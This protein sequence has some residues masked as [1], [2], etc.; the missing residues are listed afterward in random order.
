MSESIP[1]QLAAVVECVRAGRIDDAERLCRESLAVDRDDINLLGM[2]GAILLKKGQYDEA[3]RHLLRTVEL[4]P[5]FAKPYEDLGTLHLA[6]NQP[7][8]A[9]GFF[10]Q[11]L[12]LD[13][14]LA[15]AQ[16]GLAVALHRTGRQAEAAAV[17]RQAGVS[18]PA[19]R[20][21][22]EADDLRRR[23]AYEEAEQRCQAVLQREPENLV[24]LRLL[25]MIAT[26]REQFIIA[27][28][29]LRRI[30]KIAPN[31]PGA[32]LD[33]GRFLS[34]RGRYPEGIAVLEDAARQA[35][36]RPEV[37][38]LLG[39]ML[40]VVGRSADALRCY[41]SC[42]S[43]QPDDP[44]ALLGAAHMLRIE[45]RREAAEAS[46]R[47]CTERYPE[48]GE[49]WWNLAS[50]RGYC[51]T[52]TEFEHMQ[53]ALADESLAPESEV[54]FRFALARAYE[55]REDFDAAWRQYV[56]GNSRKRALV[57]Y[58]P[59]ETELQHR[60]IRDVFS[61]ELFRAAAA[62]TPAD[63]TP[64]FIVGMPRS[65]STLI[66]QIL[67][68]HSQVEG[69]GE[70]PYII[71]LTNAVNATRSDGLRYPELIPGLSASE[72]T[73]L[74]RS[75]LHH[76]GSHAGKPTRFFTDK[77]PANFSHVGFIRLI[78]PQARIIDARRDPL[79]TCVANY[80]QLFAQG[81]NQ[82]YDLTELGEYYLQY[83]EMMNHWDA[84]IP[85]AVLRVQYEQ[86]VAD[87]ETEVRRILE[88]CGL[89][90][91]T[92]CI[93]FHKSERPV[94]TASAEQVREPIYRT[95]VDYWKHYEPYLDEL[96]EVLAPVL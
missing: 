65:G 66:E 82:T 25:A 81:K 23:E 84:V 53:A 13:S 87:L 37:Q 86:V 17:Q 71:M 88:Y 11:A 96:R 61:S 83:V 73:G 80:R 49:A 35:G 28:G 54:A 1:Q 50:L 72:L 56:Q 94:N 60:K 69:K 27:E 63:Q 18:S 90:F 62:S 34:Q 14:S 32:M 89:P 92:S 57:K 68:S 41:E 3:E 33:L 39:D 77:M 8:R 47:R 43:L 7:E 26:D 38:L 44:Q 45:G 95:G 10:E 93:E 9:V 74:G 76:A 46:Y 79:A 91:E 52:Q 67:A 15:A 2:L 30:L 40:A 75:Y 12:Q 85:G 5:A 48:I 6:C 31:H 42:L 16:R 36:E 59:V 24:A 78:L 55:L 19:A 22:A 29:Y 58:D 70:L 64:V 21:L 51:P 4:E 20:Q